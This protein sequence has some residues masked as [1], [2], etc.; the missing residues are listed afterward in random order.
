MAHGPVVDVH[1][2]VLP[3]ELADDIRRR[4]RHYAMTVETEADRERFVRDD[5]HSTPMHAEFED[6]SAKLAAM[7]RRGVDIS[8]LSVTPVVFFY[9]LDRRAGI[10]AAR[11]M[12]DGVAAMARL[13]PERLWPMGTLPLQDPAASME[14]LERIVFELGF[15]SVEL[16]CVI[17]DRQL[18]HPDF[19]PLLARI[20]ELRVAVFAHPFFAGAVRPE[21]APYYLANLLGHPFDSALMA[22]HLMLSG[23]L[24]ELPGLRFILAH[25]GGHLPYQIGRLQHGYEVRPEPSERGASSPRELLRRFHFD[26]LTHDVAALR[27]LVEQAGSDRV[28]VG[29]DDPFDM[30]EADPI[31]MLDAIPGLMPTDVDRIRGANAMA[32]LGPTGGA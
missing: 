10:E 17:G 28:M 14:E 3:S 31:S 5:G 29:T 9:W 11:R 25:G 12:N 7:D 13:R 24:D 1:S 32:L 26:A 15:R 22:A 21:L 27:F 8:V 16:G 4:P 19:R 2:H 30:G 23:V 18:S 20:A 6:V